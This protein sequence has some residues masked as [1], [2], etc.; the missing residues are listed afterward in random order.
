M[1]RPHDLKVLTKQEANE[2]SLLKV[3]EWLKKNITKDLVATELRELCTQPF[4]FSVVKAVL[5]EYDSA[6]SLGSLIEDILWWQ[7]DDE[8]CDFASTWL[9]NHG[10]SLDAEK[11]A[12]S[13]LRVIPT[14]QNIEVVKNWSLDQ[15]S[16]RKVGPLA[17]LIQLGY[18]SEVEQQSE[19]C[20][21]NGIET[22][23]PIM[24]AKLSTKT[25]NRTVIQQS[26]VLAADA[27]LEDFDSA[28]L[29]SALLECGDSRHARSLA[30]KFL[31]SSESSLAK[32]DV[33]AAYL[34]NSKRNNRGIKLSLRLLSENDQFSAT[35]TE[36]LAKIGRGKEITDT[37]ERWILKYPDESDFVLDEY[38]RRFPGD[39]SR[40]IARKWLNISPACI[41]GAVLARL[42]S[43]DRSEDVVERIKEDIKIEPSILPM[44]AL[45]LAKW[46]PSLFEEDL[47]RWLEAYPVQFLGYGRVLNVALRTTPNAKFQ[48]L[49]EKWI[50]NQGKRYTYFGDKI[51]IEGELL[52]SLLKLE[53]S[54]ANVERASRWLGD[55]AFLF[56]E[57]VARDMKVLLNS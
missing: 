57:K 47:E 44:V 29:I 34:E 8:F 23:V 54:T 40:S 5:Y 10:S 18:G 9:K 39:R 3:S 1:L 55:N 21:K 25:A 36:A 20:L 7:V 50:D 13:L 17:M 52:T 27:Q 24:L 14:Q 26:E 30:R 41:H 46:K 38:L 43:Q 35:L 4:Y 42:M 53:M 12:R 37:I 22:A 33:L 28:L 31:Q 15:T 56:C 6:N 51:K 19:D 49:G 16:N 2:D 11:V 45:Q 48:A 32:A